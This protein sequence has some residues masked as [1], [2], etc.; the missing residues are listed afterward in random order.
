MTKTILVCGYGPGISSAVAERFGAEGFSVAL[1]AR[2]GDRLGAGVKALEAKG[3]RAAG[4]PIDLADP[5]A[6][7]T[8]P[9]KVREKLG[10][11]TVVDWNPYSG[12][13]GDLLTA[14]PGA[15]R[16]VLDIAITSLLVVVQAALPDLKQ[17][18]EGALL[19]I[20]GGFGYF[21]PQMDAAG[22]QFNAMG[23]SVANAAKHKLAGLL[24]KK[25]EPDGV[26]VGEAMVLGT[27]KGSAFDGGQPNTIPPSKVADKLWDLYR[28][29]A[30]VTVEIA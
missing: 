30:R 3:I 23:I 15:I 29:R 6:A 14:D 18:K 5:A 16:G 2:N 13:A 9:G 20:N 12:G 8:L 11:V 17:Q 19:I 22:V 10:P 26:Y 7:R 1:A 28:A 4:F 21:D 25:L 27:I 24:A